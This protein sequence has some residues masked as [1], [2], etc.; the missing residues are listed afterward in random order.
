MALSLNQI[1]KPLND[2]FINLYSSSADSGVMFRFDKFG[3]VISDK[4]FIDPNH[5]ELGYSANLAEEKFADLVNHVPTDAGDGMSIIFR[6]DAVDTSYFYR[7]L[8]PSQPCVSGDNPSNQDVINAFSTLKAG[9]LKQWNNL[10]L[11]SS[12]GLQLEFKPSLAGPSDWYNKDSPDVWTHQQFTISSP[13]PTPA[14]TPAPDIPQIPLSDDI[15]RMKLSDQAIRRVVLPDSIRTSTPVMKAMT[16]SL[17]QDQVDEAPALTAALRPEVVLRPEVALHRDFTMAVASPAL[18]AA[19]PLASASVHVGAATMLLSDSEQLHP[20]ETV[21]PS[22]MIHNSIRSQISMMPVSERF[23]LAQVIGTSAPTQPAAT[24]S[25]TVSFS[26]SLVKIKRPWLIDAFVS[27]ASWYIPST[28][29]GAIS[30]GTVGSPIPL[31]TIAFVTV[32]DLVINANWPAADVANSAEAT[33]FGP[34]KVDGGIAAG[35][36]SH[37]GV[38]VIGWLVQTMPSLPPNDPPA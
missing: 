15:W 4:D 14:P 7:L 2:F 18:N 34:F 24:D 23:Q 36:L 1:F 12:S 22:F 13:A 17:A 33:D 30:A 11:E 25:I 16:L 10:T 29:K 27:D 32:K 8:S 9:A 37:P 3:S 26:Y 21:A 28:P 31:S 35:N 20:L 5:P 6:Q 38:Q 19:S